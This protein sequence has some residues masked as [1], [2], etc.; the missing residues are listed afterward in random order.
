LKNQN[1]NQT[2]KGENQAQALDLE[3]LQNI[4]ERQI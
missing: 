3:N 4:I 1:Q 2:P